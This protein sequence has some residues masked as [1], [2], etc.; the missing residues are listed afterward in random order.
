MKVG[1][2][3]SKLELYPHYEIDLDNL[4]Q[5]SLDELS[6][7]ASTICQTPIAFI[8]LTTDE[9]LQI[10]SNVG[11]E[12][13][14]LEAT[15]SFYA[16]T[17]DRNDPFIVPNISIDKR[18]AKAPLVKSAPYLQFYAGVPLI[19]SNEHPIGTIS[20]G[21]ISPRELNTEQIKALKI[22]ARQIVTLIESSRDALN[23]SKLKL[24]L[25]KEILEHTRVEN[26]LNARMNQRAAV[27]RLGQIAILETD[28]L[29]LMN[30]VIEVVSETLNVEF[31]KILEFIPDSQSLVIRAAVG[32]NKELIDQ[33]LNIGKQSQAGYS[34]LLNEPV[35]LENIDA[36]KRFT[37]P[38]VLEKYGIVSGLSVIIYGQN[39]PF[40]SLCVHTKS[41]RTFNNDDIHFL[42]SVANILASAIARKESEDRLR[43]SDSRL[44]LALEAAH[45]GMWDWNLETN[46]IDWSEKQGKLL[47]LY[48]EIAEKDPDILL[49]CIHP[50]DKP[51]VI[52]AISRT[53]KER[54]SSLDLEYRIILPNGDY[55]WISGRGQFFYNKEGKAIRMIGISRDITERKRAQEEL[56]KAHNELEERVK[57]RTE[58]LLK[59]NEFLREQIEERSK[60]EEA[61]QE[62]NQ[63]LQ[64]LI[65]AS[66]LAITAI[67]QDLR[68]KMWNRAAE[69]IFGWATEEIIG[70]VLPII[71]EAGKEDYQ[72]LFENLKYGNPITE[73]ETKRQKKDGTVIDISLSA[74]P[75]FD[76]KGEFKGAMGV[77][78]DITERKRVEKALKRSEEYFRS[79]IEKAS[80]IITTL[81]TSGKIHYQSP[82]VERILGYTPEE[83]KGENAFDIIHID[84]QQYLLP[85]FTSA[86]DTSN[87]IEP[88][89]FRVRHK[90]GS[91][92]VLEAVGKKFTDESG[93]TFVVINARDITE[94]NLLKEQLLQS[95]KMEAIGRLAGGVAHDFNNLLTAI[96]GY[97]ELLLRRNNLS[98]SI[99]HQIEEIRKATNRAT[100]LT[101]QLLA[102]SRKQVLQPKIFSLTNVVTEINKLLRRLIGEDVELKLVSDSSLWDIKADPSQIEQVIM[103]LAINARDAMPDGGR[104]KIETRNIEIIEE[105]SSL[106]LNI[107]TGQYVLLSVSDTGCGIDQETQ[108]HLF[109]PFFTTKEQGKGTGLGLST[110]YGIVNQSG[111][112]ICVTSEVGKGTTF[113]VYLPRVQD[114]I[115]ELNIT[116]S[117]QEA[118]NGNETILLVEDEDMVRD[119]IQ[120]VLEINGYHILTATNGEEAL[121]LCDLYNKPI[122]LVL[123]DIVMP[124]MGG[125]ELC[126]RLSSL[127]PKTKVL[128]MSGYVEN[129]TIQEKVLK[130]NVAFLP[131]PFTP[132]ELALKL[133]EVLEEASEKRL[134]RAN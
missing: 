108:Q 89:E 56:Q 71:P 18:F 12:L 17:I 3:S 27:A 97:S 13:L 80:D 35:V 43:A 103:N 72:N 55:R 52:Q 60:I 8:T 84:D 65:Q 28:K 111:G 118:P 66:P 73:I 29:S 128:L 127:R 31:C 41:A 49:K 81:D 117:L 105:S 54:E 38:A 88:L 92:R 86:P 76:S 91:W 53:I 7:L 79:L 24:E 100:S 107:P 42:Q 125:L 25:N 4:P 126:E 121:Q 130:S 57:E 133:R 110:V 16:Y 70:R 78:A 132:N 11:V 34:L 122:D 114:G 61:L 63:T 6:Y 2:N 112:H 37:W 109:E 94:R 47:G 99:R 75:L 101:H 102:F 96:T 20:I 33:T 124:Q 87:G 134:K 106:P 123:S 113:D 115:K 131:K 83:L 68:V 51:V 44:R 19:I 62:S 129:K 23:L 95:Q 93:E 9:G 64:A 59:T 14:D 30:K 40:G 36:E 39:R 119:M 82:S 32:W 74:A 85:I 46:E 77:V 120:E 10:V 26:E 58:S 90:D 67:D 45:M 116:N 50:E 98:T 15:S 104:L 21:D 1:I 22:I 5:N 48:P 69:Q